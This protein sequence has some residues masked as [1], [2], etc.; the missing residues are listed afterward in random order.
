VR[1][2][3]FVTYGVL[4]CKVIQ[5]LLLYFQAGREVINH[6]SLQAGREEE[7]A[8]LQRESEMPLEELIKTLPPEIFDEKGCNKESSLCPDKEKIASVS[9]QKVYYTVDSIVYC[10]LTKY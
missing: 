1:S 3:N 8:A 10:R 9:K 6:F 2:L 7:L 4:P 5:I